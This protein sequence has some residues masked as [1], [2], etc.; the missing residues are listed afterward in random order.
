MELI[1]IRLL[2]LC[3]LKAKV[4]SLVL[5]YTYCMELTSKLGIKHNNISEVI[6]LM[7]KSLELFSDEKDKSPE[8]HLIPFLKTYYEVTKAV[9]FHHSSDEKY[10]EDYTSMEVLDIVFAELYFH[11]LADFLE[12]EQ[13]PSPWFNYF[14]YC[15]TG[16]DIPFL[17]MLLGINVHI[18]GD[19]ANAINKTD[20]FNKNDFE[21][22]NEILLEVLPGILSYLA[23]K[24]HDFLGFGGLILKPIYLKAFTDIIV[25]WRRNAWDNAQKLRDGLIDLESIHE[26]AEG[27]S[28]LLI[29]L[30][31]KYIRID[32][33]LKLLS[34]LKKV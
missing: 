30:W 31:S 29:D 34:E 9:Q 24:E 20:Y 15:K 19:L 28:I 5:F 25:K 1:G 3:K 22:I 12:K 33:K 2:V 21:K 16:R 13:A 6:S 23:W 27:K 11:P 26:D 14:E 7:E 17:Q 8:N 10:F 32:Q 4:K 18:N